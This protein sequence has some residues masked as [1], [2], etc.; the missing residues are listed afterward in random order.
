M[1][2][3][4]KQVMQTIECEA[5]FE[6]NTGV[7]ACNIQTMPLSG[8]FRRSS[9][10]PTKPLTMEFCD[11]PACNLMRTPWLL[12]NDDYPLGK[13]WQMKALESM[14]LAGSDRFDMII[15]LRNDRDVVAAGDVSFKMTHTRMTYVQ[16]KSAL[17]LIFFLMNAVGLCVFVH[18]LRQ[19]VRVGGVVNREQKMVVLALIWSVMASEPF[20]EIHRI[21]LVTFARQISVNIAAIVNSGQLIFWIV[22]LD[23][24]R[25]IGPMNVHFFIWPTVLFFVGLGLLLWRYDVAAS[26]YADEGDVGNV[27]TQHL[28]TRFALLALETV[29]NA[30]FWG[31]IVITSRVVSKL[32]YLESRYRQLSFRFLVFRATFRRAAAFVLI[33]V[34]ALSPVAFLTDTHEVELGFSVFFSVYCLL[35]N[36][37]YLP[38]TA[39]IRFNYFNVTLLKARNLDGTIIDN[40]DSDGVG[41]GDGDSG[42]D[43]DIGG[44][45]YI[46]GDDDAVDNRDEMQRLRPMSEPPQLS[47]G[48]AASEASKK[49]TR[50]DRSFSV[51]AMTA[52]VSGHRHLMK[53]GLGKLKSFAQRARSGVLKSASRMKARTT[54]KMQAARARE[55]GLLYTYSPLSAHVTPRPAASEIETEVVMMTARWLVSFARESYHT[56]SEKDT[57]AQDA[58]DADAAINLNMGVKW[59]KRFARLPGKFNDTLRLLS[60]LVSSS[61]TFVPYP[62]RYVFN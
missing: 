35:L 23:S 30:W 15:V 10:T 50:L 32:S 54:E 51:T 12:N 8:A 26:F 13:S 5:V 28:A 1:V 37:L 39:G 25:V 34:A 55:R 14:D 36:Y 3:R 59:D 52:L 18:S 47:L 42:G 60:S 2:R 56:L 24:L 21:F 29:W 43:R 61:F 48:S 22:I 17:S 11:R 33:V 20:R 6:D 7:D 53:R 9:S 62:A 44:A 46:D 27:G 19:H 16:V 38:I 57:F 41:D 31:S 40:G 4:S 45:K 58:R 49:R